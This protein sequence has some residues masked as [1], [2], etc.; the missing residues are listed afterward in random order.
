MTSRAFG[1]LLPVSLAAAAALLAAASARAEPIVAGT[2]TLYGR[3]IQDITLVPGTPLNQGSSEV[4][5]DGL[6]GDGYL[7]F[8][9]DAQVGS[10]IVM[11]KATG[12]FSGTEA[13]LGGI[14]YTFGAVGTLTEDDF[15]GQ[16]TD[17]VQDPSSPGYATGD[18]SSLIGG[19]LTFGGASFGFRFDD[20]PLAG[21]VVYTAPTV[22]FAFEA[23]LDGLPPSPGTT[24]VSIGTDKIPILADGAVVGYTST[25][26]IVITAVPEPSSLLLVGL[27]GLAGLAGWRRRGRPSAA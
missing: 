4:V 16:I 11:P 5:L 19:T 18:P 27:G 20:G 1:R 3:A 24:L 6:F 23:T 26:R 15:S 13:R 14:S 7:T 22:P 10:T 12:Q 17:V 2:S 8:I 21:L 25:R 9:R